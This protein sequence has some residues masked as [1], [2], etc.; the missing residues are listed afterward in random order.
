MQLLV[1]G[2]ATHQTPYLFQNETPIAT[3]ESSLVCTTGSF[4][5]TSAVV[6]K[7]A[8]WV[9]VPVEKHIYKIDPLQK[10]DVAAIPVGAK[11]SAVG[12]AEIRKP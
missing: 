4:L 11:L 5:A 7:D 8:V 12:H 10:K 2:Y 9:V 1:S 3:L 6:T